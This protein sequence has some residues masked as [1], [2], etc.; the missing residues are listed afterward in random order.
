VL[1]AGSASGGVYKSTDYGLNWT[2]IFDEVGVMSIG[3]VAIDPDDPDLVYVGTGEANSASDTYEGT[4]IYK[5]TDGGLSWDNIGLPY[6]YH[7]S[8]I[9]VDPLRPETLYVG[10]MGR[11]FGATNPERGLYRSTD[12]GATW[13]KKLYLTD[14]TCCVDV[15]LHPSSGTVFA[16]MWEKVRY[17][18]RADFSG[19]TSGIYRSTDFGDS[20]TELTNGLP[21][22]ADHIGRIGVSVDPNSQTVYSLYSDGDGNFEGAYK[23]IDLGDTWVRT[24]DAAMTTDLYGYPDYQFGWYF[25]NIR[26]APGNPDVAY[27]LGV[28]MFKTT[29]G[30]G[31]WFTCDP[32][33]HV[34][35]HCMYIWPDNIS[36]VFSGSDGGV[37]MT[38]SGGGQWDVR[39]NMGNT[40]FYAI[41]IDNGDA[42]VLMGGTQDNGTM[43]TLG[44]GTGDWIEILGGDGFYC[45]IDYTDSDIIYAESQ[46][47]N[48]RKSTDRGQSFFGA[49]NGIDYNNERHGWSTPIAM[50]PNHPNILY[51]GSNY[52]YKTENGAGFWFKISGDLTGGPGLEDNSYI[53]TIAPAASDSEVVYAATNDANVWVTTNGGTDWNPINSGLPNRWVTRV[54][55]DR[56]DA[57]VAYVTLSGYGEASH[58]PHVFRTADYGG[59]WTDISGDLPDAPVNDLVIDFYADSFLYIA[60]DFGVFATTNGG[61]NWEPLGTDMPINAVHDLAFHTATRTLV[62]GTH[63]RSMYKTTVPCP[64]P[65]DSD[66]DGVG[67][68]C[69]NCPNAANPDQDD[70][71]VDG[72]GDACD[73]CTDSDGD[74]FGNPGYAA[75]TCPDDNCPE[76]YNPDQTETD[77]DGI[78]DLCDFR[79]MS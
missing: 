49:L 2:P 31:S 77:G 24:S 56:N 42:S 71:D 73:D 3:A 52:L 21:S 62:A 51:Y 6:S 47:G 53:T 34:D 41:T 19:M 59:T 48:L 35:H 4:G 39:R 11:H 15:A 18:D 79:Y 1:Y 57:A 74:G 26:V 32:G 23:S 14:S 45:L 63:G 20:W 72:T 37:A 61:T 27:A 12:G 60:T 38:A 58:L 7:I 65:T 25:G 10:A 75:N 33:L 68:L 66:A 55:V 44:G 69:D 17:L 5:S 13:E 22:P 46:Y 16:C 36:V 9:V 70:A 28:R 30:G 64:D 40:Q 54:T 29:D 67:D 8:R 43:H 78:G 76:V 50:D